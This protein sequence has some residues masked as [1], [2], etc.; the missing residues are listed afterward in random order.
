MKSFTGGL[1]FRLTV[2]TYVLVALFLAIAGFT[3]FRISQD[4]IKIGAMEM[5]EDMADDVQVLLD[6]NDSVEEIGS[7]ILRRKIKKTGSA[8]IMDSEGNMLYNPDPDFRD[9]YIRDRKKFGNVVVNLQYASPRPSGQGVFKEKLSD[10]VGK[11]EEG[12]G[13]Y[14]Q[15]G[16]K[17][18]LA[19]RTIPGKGLLIGV[20]EP[21]SSANSELERIK[22]YILYTAV[23]SAVNQARG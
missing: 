20:D 14:S 17:R 15:F 21:L 19:F 23:V 12:F 4:S 22:K 10:I 3:V 11:Y 1:G 8:W 7:T 16:E 5:V 6:V 9:E 13:T 18:I 2:T